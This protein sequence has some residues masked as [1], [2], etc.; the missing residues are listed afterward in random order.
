MVVPHCVV[1]FGI[2]PTES[3]PAIFQLA[4]ASRSAGRSAGVPVPTGAE[5]EALLPPLLP[6]QLQL[7]GPVPLVAEAEPL[8]HKFDVGALLTAVPL[9]AP[10]LPLMSVTASGAEQEASLPPLVPRQLQVQGPVPLTDP[11]TPALHKLV[12][13][14]LLT[15]TPFA[16]PQEP[17]IAVG[18][19]GAEQL[20]VV[21]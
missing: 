11:D 1:R 18:V 14:V 15:E 2:P 13:G 6:L 9:A 19:T 7:H 10:Q 4:L 21:P 16:L 5:H 20:A 12:V 3:I 8:L 17:L